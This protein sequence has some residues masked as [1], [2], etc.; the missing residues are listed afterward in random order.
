MGG[1]SR[2]EGG[3]E[4]VPNLHVRLHSL[5]SEAFASVLLLAKKLVDPSSALSPYVQ[6]KRGS[7]GSHLGTA[8]LLGSWAV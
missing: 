6:D 2:A 4:P 7:S 1:C 3:V 8:G 5:Y